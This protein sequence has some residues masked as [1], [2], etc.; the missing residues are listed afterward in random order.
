MSRRTEKAYAAAEAVVAAVRAQEPVGHGELEGI[1]VVHVMVGQSVGQD[2]EPGIR[3]TWRQGDWAF[4][5]LM[6]FSTVVEESGGIDSAA[7]YLRLAVDEPHGPTPDDSRLWF[8][9]LPSGPY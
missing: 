5:L 9:D 8:V 7:F 3:M 1:D 2:P 4:G 6:P